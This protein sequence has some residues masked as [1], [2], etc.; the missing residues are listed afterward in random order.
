MPV[1]AST[2]APYAPPATIMEVIRRFR[3]R[4]M[5]APFTRDVLARAGVPD[6][7]IP[8]TLQSLRALDLIDD[9]GNPSEVLQGLA[10]ASAEN[11][12]ARM[13]DWL[14]AAYAEVF[15]FADPAKD[16][17]V[18]VRDAFRTYTPRGQQ[19]R[20]VTLFLTL[21]QEAGIRGS[22][23]DSPRRRSAQQ[24]PA[25]A[26]ARSG[27]P[28]ETQSSRAQRRE[29]ATQPSGEVP[30]AIAGLLASLPQTARWSAASRE[31]FLKTFEAVLDFC[32]EVVDGDPDDGRGDGDE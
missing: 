30:Q 10:L 14:R 26:Q 28:G 9:A 20:M 6:S 5:Q 21:C 8:R 32:V 2:P 1:T 18:R 22:G 3:D 29:N 17:T 4:G 11:F 15:Q 7:L 12:P 31:K 25:R 27:R 23:E 13:S 16:D 24:R 19:D